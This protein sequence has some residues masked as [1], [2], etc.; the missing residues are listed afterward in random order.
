MT[1]RSTILLAFAAWAVCSPV[2]AEECQDTSAK[3]RTTRFSLI[4]TVSWP[5]LLMPRDRK[6]CGTATIDGVVGREV[7]KGMAAALAGPTTTYTR[8][9]GTQ[10][11]VGDGTQWRPFPR[12]AK[13]AQGFG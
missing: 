13:A 5:S 4:I 3:L 2:R 7:D 11:W 12:A 6:D 10:T 9:D 8:H 1:T